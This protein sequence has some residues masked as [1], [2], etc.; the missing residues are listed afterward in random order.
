MIPPITLVLANLAPL[1]LEFDENQW[2]AWT[3]YSTSFHDNPAPKDLLG[4]MRKI[5][6]NHTDGSYELESRYSPDYLREVEQKAKE[7]TASALKL[8]NSTICE[9][10]P[11]VNQQH[12]HFVDSLLT[13]LAEKSYVA[14]LGTTPPLPSQTIF[15]IFQGKLDF[16]PLKNSFRAN[17]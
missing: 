1:L 2:E 17:F 11:K 4:R 7:G 13:S 5:Y 3:R 6:E 16:S 15:G 14:E 9:K 12:F 10:K 8:W